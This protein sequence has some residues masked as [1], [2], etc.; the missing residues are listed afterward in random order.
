[1]KRIFTLARDP[2][3]FGKVYFTIATEIPEPEWTPLHKGFYGAVL[4]D[5]QGRSHV[6]EKESGALIGES[7]D[8][9]NSDIDACADISFMWGQVIKAKENCAEAKLVPVESFWE[10]I[11]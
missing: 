11:R 2:F 4:I 1:M 8:Q 7:I 5:S 10:N 9:V 6:I 3:A